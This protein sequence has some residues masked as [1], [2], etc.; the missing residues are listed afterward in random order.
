VVKAGF[1]ERLEIVM[2]DSSPEIMT[3]YITRGEA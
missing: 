2:N 3:T 1:A